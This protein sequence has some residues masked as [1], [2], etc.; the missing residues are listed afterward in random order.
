MAKVFRVAKD[1][2]TKMNAD[3]QYQLRSGDCAL[4]QSLQHDSTVNRTGHTVEQCDPAVACCFDDPATKALAAASCPGECPL[5]EGDRTD[6]VGFHAP[7]V[8]DNIREEYVCG[9]TASEHDLHQTSGIATMIAENDPWGK[10]ETGDANRLEV[11]AAEFDCST[12][13]IGPAAWDSVV[14][15]G[16]GLLARCPNYPKAALPISGRV[17]N[18]CGLDEERCR[19]S[20]LGEAVELASCCA[21]GDEVLIRARIDDLPPGTIGP[22][23]A[24]GFSPAQICAR[25]AWNRRYGLYDWRPP[26]YRGAEVD[27]IVGT[28]AVNG[29]AVLLPADGV[30]IG[31]REAGD[32]VATAVADSNGCAAG[33]TKAQA[34]EAALLELVERDAT[35]RWWYG[36]RLRP[37]LPATLLDKW[38]EL[39]RWLDGRT[40]LTRLLDLTTE[41]G[42]PVV[43]AVSTASNGSVP[44][45]GFAARF[46]MVEAAGAAVAEMLGVEA[47]LLS[48]AEQPDPLTAEWL[49][50]SPAALPPSG[51]EA[52][53]ARTK[54]P[55]EPDTRLAAAIGALDRAGCRIV[56]VDLTR[57]ALGVPVIRAMAPDL[58]HYKPRFGYHRLLAPD[59]HD[60][61]PV[62]S[63]RPNPVPLLL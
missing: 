59:L 52:T 15:P 4:G 28:D 11:L 48:T 35:G 22:R 14:V 2:L 21:W 12:I 18:G 10:N 51:P 33:A 1:H 19:L 31:L 6:L 43:A 23:E 44:A 38:P 29:A 62:S 3:P 36:R 5:D 13:R 53:D 47:S 24:M 30:L 54:T 32:K 63:I 8:A 45:L 7:T 61:A 25:A 39:T 40:R 34:M 60:L 49:A 42:I 50:R 41:I 56:F 55:A 20:G 57:P 17:A 37:S 26:A 16:T 9:R 58:C 27:W 46:E